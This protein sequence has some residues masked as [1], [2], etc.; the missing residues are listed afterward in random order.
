MNIGFNGFCD[1]TVTFEADATVKKGTLLKL[2]DDNTVSVCDEGDKVVGVCVNVREGY[3]AVKL[4]GYAEIPVEGAVNVG[5]QNLSAASS[6]AFKADA[7]GR[8]Y[9]VVSAD[10]DTIGVI[11]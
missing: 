11:L 7:N 10:T 9:L 2:I 5:Y 8:E 1:N 4:F 6:E 3:A